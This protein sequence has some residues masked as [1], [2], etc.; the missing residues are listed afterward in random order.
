V[1]KEPKPPKEPKQPKEPKE[2]RV[3]PQSEIDNLQEARR[4]AAFYKNRNKEAVETELANIEDPKERSKAVRE[5]LNAMYKGLT[6]VQKNHY[7]TMMNEST[8]A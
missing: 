4:L 6:P 1:S 8:Q 2:K 7:K 3:K 5:R